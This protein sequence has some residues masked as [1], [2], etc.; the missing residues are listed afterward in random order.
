MSFSLTKFLQVRGPTYLQ[1]KVKVRA[2]QSEFQLVAFEAFIVEDSSD[3]YHISQRNDTAIN[4]ALD[5]AT[6]FSMVIS[7]I[8]TPKSMISMCFQP[9]TADWRENRNP[10]TDLL[11]DFIDG[12]FIQMG[13]S[14]TL[15][16]FTVGDDEFRSTRFKLIP[17]LVEGPFLLRHLLT[18]RPV[19]MGNKGLDVKYYREPRYLEV[20]T[21]LKK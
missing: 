20:S 8:L 2:K 16:W 7:L 5:A 14:H 3:L 19:I 18:P 10:F 12:T 13:A 17:H 4:K 9:K 21:L 6:D 15:M 1:D 11:L